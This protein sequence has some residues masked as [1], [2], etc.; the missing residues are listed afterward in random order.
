MIE[1]GMELDDLRSAQEDPSTA[2]LPQKEKILLM[3][4]LKIVLNSDEV[5]AADLEIAYA[6]GWEDRDIYEAANYTVRNYAV[7]LLLKAL[8]VDGQGAFD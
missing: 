4:V 6:N 7:D 1:N 8:K 5:E 2:P 3:L